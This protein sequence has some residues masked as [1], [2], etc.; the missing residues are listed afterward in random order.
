[1]SAC[2]RL[3]FYAE[4]N[5]FLPP[6]QRQQPLCC[7]FEPPAPV[8]H[9]I[10]TYGVPHSE[11]ELVLVNGASV[12]LE[13]AVQDGDR[14]SVYPMFEGLDIRPLLRLRARPLRRI[15]FVADAHLG[16]LARQ[17]RMLG[18]DTLFRNAWPDPEL[19]RISARSGRILL[20][21][22]RALLMR[23]EITHGCFVRPQRPAEQLA[24]L[25]RRLD[26]CAEIRPFSRCMVCNALVVGVSKEAVRAALPP[27][28]AAVQERFHR[29]T[30]CAKVYWEGS[31]YRAMQ[32][33]IAG[34][35]EG[36][37]MAGQRRSD[38]PQKRN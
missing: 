1:M 12:G 17:L 29:C 21:R 25:I 14:I 20:T 23:R 18:F 6:P 26:L 3:R 10:E 2:A 16:R 35:C 22:D 15:R 8:R 31:H 27:R 34:L 19:A 11:V 37:S 32:Q 13:Q 4:L 5:D 33:R 30:G 7:R 28:A 36:A 24:A 9:L 38:H